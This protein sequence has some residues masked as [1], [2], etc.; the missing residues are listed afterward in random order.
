MCMYC[1]YNGSADFNFSTPCANKTVVTGTQRF[2]NIKNY[3][4]LKNF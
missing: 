2:K 3:L 4:G 1:Q